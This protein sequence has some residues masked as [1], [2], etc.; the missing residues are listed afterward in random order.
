LTRSFEDLQNRQPHVSVNA[1]G[2][3]VDPQTLMTS[4]GTVG[5]GDCLETKLVGGAELA[6][7]VAVGHRMSFMNAR[8]P[9]PSTKV[10][11]SWQERSRARLEM[12]CAQRMKSSR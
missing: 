4:L 9:E 3:F 6:A 7:S 10:C 2:L 8:Q 1:P 5:N 12:S 11:V